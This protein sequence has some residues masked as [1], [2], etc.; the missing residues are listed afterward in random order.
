MLF[1]LLID[2]VDYRIVL[3]GGAVFVTKRDKNPEKHAAVKDTSCYSGRGLI[4]LALTS[5]RT[6]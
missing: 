3:I 5:A 2:E 1:V 4:Y 6:H